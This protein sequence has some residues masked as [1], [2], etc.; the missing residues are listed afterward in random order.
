MHVCAAFTSLE[1]EPRGNEGASEVSEKC[2][3]AGVM[4]SNG[5][6]IGHNS[7]YVVVN[8]STYIVLWRNKN[9]LSTYILL[10][11]N[12]KHRY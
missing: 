5:K 9:I 2:R 11:Y 6:S 3:A 4:Y 8:I 10:I 12:W 7:M 1:N